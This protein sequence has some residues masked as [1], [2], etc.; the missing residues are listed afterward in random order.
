MDALEM[1]GRKVLFCKIDKPNLIVS[2]SF[3]AKRIFEIISKDIDEIIFEGNFKYIF[4]SGVISRLKKYKKLTRVPNPIIIPKIVSSYVDTILPKEK[5]I[6][7][8]SIDD[9][10]VSIYESNRPD[11]IYFLDFPEAKLSKNELIKVRKVFNQVCN[12]VPTDI[13]DAKYSMKNIIKNFIGKNNKLYNVFVRNTIGYGLI[14]PILSDEQVEDVF[15]DSCSGLV[16]I[17]HSRHGECI[18]NIFVSKNEI[19]KIKTRIRSESGRPLDRSSPVIHGEILNGIR[20]CVVQDPCTYSGTGFA[21]RKRKNVPWSLKNLVNEKMLD[22]KTAAFLSFILSG[23]NSILITGPRSSGKTT[24]LTALLME[25]PQNMRIIIVEDTPEIP[26][27]FLRKLGYKIEH[28]RTESFSKG[29]ELTAEEAIRTTLRLGNSVLVFGEVRG[30]EARFLFEAMRFG[31]AGNVVIGTIHG[32]GPKD[33]FDR[34]VNDL[35]VPSSSFKAVDVVLTTGLIKNKNKCDKRLLGVSEIC[36]EWTEKP[37]IKNIVSYNRFRDKWAI[38]NFPFLMKKSSIVMGIRASE[39][40]KNISLREK[41]LKDILYEK[42]F[43]PLISVKSNN[44]LLKLLATTTDYNL[45][46]TKWKKWFRGASR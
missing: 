38:G 18:A 4:N 42:V 23:Y 31:G 40:K 35:N 36:N 29:N 26:V 11:K 24:L 41:I 30:K 20:V 17:I 43:D 3:F 6:D 2:K 16:H 39:I 28:L 21:F 22:C 45:V 9:V 44:K 34:L 25:M 15:I 46:Y 10:N 1:F 13:H 7:K 8:Y 27:S 33:T 19:E 37:K 5:L 32:S 12:S 14:E